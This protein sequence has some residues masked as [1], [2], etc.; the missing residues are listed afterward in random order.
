MLRNPLDVAEPATPGARLAGLVAEPVTAPA[1]VHVPMRAGDAPRRRP[2]PAPA[3]AAPGPAPAAPG[4]TI[5]AIR[6]G[7]RT[8]EWTK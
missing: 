7:K 3:A 2:E 6:A 8:Q 5:E 4:Y 1:I